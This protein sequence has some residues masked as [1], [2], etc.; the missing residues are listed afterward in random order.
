TSGIQSFGSA[1]NFFF[2]A[3]NADG[4]IDK[5][6]DAANYTFTSILE[7][8]IVDFGDID[9]DKTLLT[10]KI[11]FVKLTSGQ[12]VVLKYKVDDQTSWTTVGSYSTVGGVSKTFLNIE[13]TGDNFSSGHEFRFRIESLGGCQI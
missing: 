8:Q 13:S 1:G 2:I 11:S 3:Y 6:D 4:S 9:P 7:T 10:F 5:T 12:S